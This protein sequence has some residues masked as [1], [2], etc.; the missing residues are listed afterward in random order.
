MC[1]GAE[2][3]LN[4]SVEL[5]SVLPSW[6]MR[7]CAQLG[8]FW[9]ICSPSWVN[10]HVLPS[11]VWYSTHA[12]Q[13]GHLQVLPNDLVTLLILS[14]VLISCVFVVSL[15]GTFL[16]GASLSEPLIGASLSEPLNGRKASPANYLSI[17]PSIYVCVRLSVNAL[18]L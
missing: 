18:A 11:W 1:K 4:C 12:A 3:F 13:L 8:T 9:Y 6:A 5:D 14:V 16:V 10:T 15:M 7:T 2:A 17:Y